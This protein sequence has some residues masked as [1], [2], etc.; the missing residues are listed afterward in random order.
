[1][2]CPYNAEIFPGAVFANRIPSAHADFVDAE[3]QSLIDSF[4]K[5]NTG[6]KTINHILARSGITFQEGDIHIH[7][8]QFSDYDYIYFLVTIGLLLQLLL[9]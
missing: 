6:T 8:V 9:L 5:T 1:M 4:Q 7:T 3:M 2:T